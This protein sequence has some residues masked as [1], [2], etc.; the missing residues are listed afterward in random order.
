L[1]DIYIKNIIMKKVVRLTESDLRRV[2]KRI[3][4]ENKSEDMARNAISK[5]KQADRGIMKEITKCITSGSYSHLMVLTTGVGAT[6]LGALAALFASGIGTAPAL[7][8]MAAGVI[9]TGIEGILTSDELNM[10]AGSVSDELERL[11]NCLKRKGV[12]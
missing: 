3:I 5:S 12:I 7:I 1:I 11:Y 9:I 6:A 2:V 4:N 10:G 8:L